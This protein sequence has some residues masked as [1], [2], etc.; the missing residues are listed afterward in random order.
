MS[1][2]DKPK[3]IPASSLKTLGDQVPT[4]ELPVAFKRLD[5]SE[6]SI[7]FHAKGM[8]KT[9]WAAVK[10]AF[11]KNIADVEAAKTG[12]EGDAP[13]TEAEAPAPAA[14]F[15]LAK[16]VGEGLARS[17]DLVTEFATGWELTD[18]FGVETLA[19]LE[20]RFG[21]SLNRI[22]EA[23]DAATFQGRL[24]NSAQ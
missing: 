19:D 12:A 10:D 6:F 23:Y 22:V 18:P 17:A 9:E 16:V 7:T 8:R 11:R 4:F 2:T 24:G 15:S 20:D 3:S 13:A 21:G 5:G 1:K 14:E